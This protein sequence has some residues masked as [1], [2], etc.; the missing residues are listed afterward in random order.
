M[1]ATYK[2]D[3]TK[4]IEDA[5]MRLLVPN[6]LMAWIRASGK[7]RADIQKDIWWLYRFYE[8]FFA[9]EDTGDHLDIGRDYS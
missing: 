7:Y 6:T 5:K 4:E 2:V 9:I 8:K 3:V 1:P